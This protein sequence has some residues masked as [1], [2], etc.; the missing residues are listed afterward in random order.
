MVLAMGVIVA[1]LLVTGLSATEQS[2]V[3]AIQLSTPAPTPVPQ[4]VPSTPTIMGPTLPAATP[5]PTAETVIEIVPQ[6]T[7]LA[8]DPESNRD[9]EYD[10]DDDDESEDD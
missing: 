8:D 7:V 5:I 1:T 6:P 9:E 2:P 10:D 4:T 3:P